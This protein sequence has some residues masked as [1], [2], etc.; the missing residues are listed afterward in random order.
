MAYRNLLSQ[1]CTDKNELFT[2]MRDFIC[3]RSGTYDYSSLGIGWTLIDSSYATDEDNCAINDWYVIYSPGEGAKDDL[4][5]KITWASGYLKTQGYQAWDAVAHAGGGVYGTAN[6]FTMA[7]TASKTLWVYGDLDAVVCIN[8]VTSISYY[9]TCWGILSP[10]W[11][12]QTG[13]IAQCNNTL[14]AGSDVT[15][16]MA[17]NVPSN[18][19]VGKELF[20]RTTHDDAVATVEMEKITIKTI[21]VNYITADLVD[22][23]TTGSRISDFVGYSVASANQGL[24]AQKVIMADD[25][26]RNYNSTLVYLTLATTSF[27]PGVYEDKF[28]LLQQILYGVNGLFGYQKHFRRV[29]TFVA[30]FTYGD[31]LE[32]DDGTEWRCF[33][34][35]S[36]VYM[37][38]KEV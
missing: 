4:Y 27:D 20:I 37:A 17:A 9:G 34:A 31:I 5:F 2:R 36:N 15:I 33:K 24:S 32:D 6:N 10:L 11:D 18:W 7:E 19:A 23:Y 3:R 14:T 16:Q 22:S 38:V 35:Y 12:S 1:A 30:G 25:G 29:P 21:G 26:T 28:Y 8:M 13:E